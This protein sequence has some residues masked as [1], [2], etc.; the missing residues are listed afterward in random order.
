MHIRIHGEVLSANAKQEVAVRIG[1]QGKIIATLAVVL[2]IPI[3]YRASPMWQVTVVDESGAP[4]EGMT[5]RR[6]YQNCSTETASHEDDQ[7][8]DKQGH[9]AFRKVVQRNNSS[10]VRLYWPFGSCGC[11]REFR[12]PRLRFRVRERT[13]RLRGQRRLCCRLDRRASADGIAYHRHAGWRL[14]AASTM[15]EVKL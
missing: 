11:P 8:T 5:V 4:V 15:I 2:L 13:R 9:A 6:V 1:T 10:S 12:A 3:P 7:T 14:P